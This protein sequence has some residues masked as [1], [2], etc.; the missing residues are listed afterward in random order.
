M[1][2]KAA[3]QSKLAQASDHQARRTKGKYRLESLLLLNNI[4]RWQD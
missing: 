2:P 4:L 1:I 3:V